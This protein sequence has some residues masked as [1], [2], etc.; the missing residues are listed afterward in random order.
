MA[1]PLFALIITLVISMIAPV[2]VFAATEPKSKPAPVSKPEPVGAL[3]GFSLTPTAGGYSFTGSEH[4]DPVQLYGLKIGYDNIG[5]SIA[6]SLGVEATFNYFTT[7]SKAGVNDATGY[8]VRLDAIY[9]FVLSSKWMPCLAIGAGGIAIDT[10]TNSDFKK[11]LLLNYGL[12]LKYFFE[13]YLAVRVDGRHL[14]VY[15]NSTPKNN[16][17]I[18]IGVSYYFGKERTKKTEPPP[19]TKPEVK[20]DPKKEK[21]VNALVIFTTIAQKK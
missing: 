13:N 14:M 4:R 18:G 21:I 6:D 17:E 3:G 10:G 19:K 8:L 5:K 1:K 20:A 2:A 16:F 11:N 7:K 9:P 12:G 15:D